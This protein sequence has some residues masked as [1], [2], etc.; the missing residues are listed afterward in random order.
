MARER[1]HGARTNLAAGLTSS[2]T[3]LAYYAI[4]YGARAALSEE[5]RHAKTHRGTWD[6]FHEAFVASGRFDA[7]LSSQ[8]RAAQ[9]A[10]EDTDYDARPI[11]QDEAEGLVALAERFLAEIELLVGA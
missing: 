8:A 11:P 2:A 4:L 6:L 9:R 3:S 5:D 7:G 1:L 10:R